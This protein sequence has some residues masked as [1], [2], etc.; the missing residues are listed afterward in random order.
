[1]TKVFEVEGMTCGGCEQSV[2]RAISALPGVEK[3]NASH[4]AKKVEVEGSADPQQI[5]DAIT[6]AG[7]EVLSGPSN[8]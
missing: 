8:A 4:Q 2:T 3:V 1:M 7:Y 5:A 6:D